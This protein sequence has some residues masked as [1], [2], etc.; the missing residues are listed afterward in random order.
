MKIGVTGGTGFIGSTLCRKLASDGH[1]LT[2]FGRSEKRAKR[3]V[4]EAHFVKW[5]AEEGPA[6]DSLLSGFDAFV[7]LAGEPIAAGRW[8]ACRKKWISESRILGTRSLVEGFHRCKDAPGVLISSSAIGFYGNRGDVAL[9][10][11]SPPGEGFLPD[12]AVRWEEEASK[13]TDLGTRLVLLRTGIVLSR[14][15]GALSKMLAPFKLGLGGRLGSG[16]QYMSWIHLSDQIGLIDFALKSSSLKGPLNASAP[17]PVTNLAFTKELGRVLNRPA[18]F[19]V[20][21]F[22]LR[23]VLGEMGNTLLLEGQK[24]LPQKALSAGYEFRF[25]ELREALND[26]LK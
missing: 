24:V 4:P 12:V 8:S 22:V 26:L 16:T 18:L 3:V 14:E 5:S 9:V 21:G 11:D 17:Q 10:E 19:R 7:H 13:V 2:L 20:P 25:P 23:L 6:T 15:G 1:Q